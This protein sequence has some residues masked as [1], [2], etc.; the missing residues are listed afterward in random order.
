M[1]RVMHSN[2]QNGPMRMHELVAAGNKAARLK[3]GWTQDD[4]ARMLRMNGL[5]SWRGGTVGQLEAGLRRPRLDELLVICATLEVSLDELLPGEDEQVELGDAATMTPRAMR[6]LLR[7]Y[8]KFNR[9]SFSDVHFP[10]RSEV[11]RLA[12][13]MQTSGMS[14]E[15]LNKLVE[16]I[17]QAGSR[18]HITI[19]VLAQDLITALDT[20]AEAERHA[21]RQL[22]LEPVQVRLASR[23]LW[24]ADFT[25]ERD[26]RVGDVNELEPR[27]RQARRGLVAREMLGELRAFFAETEAAHAEWVPYP[28]D[29]GEHFS[30]TI[31][32]IPMTPDEWREWEQWKSSRQT[33]RV[34]HKGL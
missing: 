7:D 28:E 17:M 11:E 33:K 5:F 2:C 15:Q 29:A 26:R 24:K 9:L 13:R 3:K 14:H 25:A 6:A 32:G 18:K 4:E 1:L 22:G 8:D 19:A 34:I 12:A 16:P 21:A 20:P 31:A 27:S 23:V 30:T 10:G